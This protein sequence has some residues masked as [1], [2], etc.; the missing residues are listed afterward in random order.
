MANAFQSSRDVVVRT[1]ALAEAADFYGSVLGLPVAHKSE[2]LVGFETG[3]FCLY[4][5]LGKE[6]G[7]VFEFLVAQT[8]SL[9]RAD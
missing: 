2:T 1:N 8:C 9:Q 4:V 7:L 3:A 5:E 6:H